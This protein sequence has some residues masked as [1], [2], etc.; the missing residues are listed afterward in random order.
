MRQFSSYGPIDTDLHYHAPRSELQNHAYQQL[1]GEDPN[2]GGHYLTVWAPRQTGK[3]WLLQQVMRRKYE[4]PYTD[5]D[6]GVVVQPLFV[7]TG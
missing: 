4:A 5:P 1:V 3:T 2:K 6:T 7:T